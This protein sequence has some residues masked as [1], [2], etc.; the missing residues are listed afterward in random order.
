MPI[1][2]SFDVGIKNMAVC[3]FDC[4][5]EVPSILEWT[6]L[7]MCSSDADSEEKPKCNYITP[8]KKKSESGKECNKVAK[9]K[10]PCHSQSCYF[11]PVHAKK[12]MNIMPTD[13][14]KKTALSKMDITSLHE[15]CDKYGIAKFPTKSASSENLQRHFETYALL[16]ISSAKKKK[17]NEMDL[18]SIGRKMS[19]LLDNM[20]ILKTVDIVI[21]ENQISPIANRMKTIQGMLTQYFII[22]NPECNIEY[23]SS[24]NK[25][26]SFVNKKDDTYKQHKLDAVTIVSGFKEDKISN[27]S[28]W[29]EKMQSAKKKDD[30]ADCFLQ[31]IWYM[32][33]RINNAK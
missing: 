33:S 25:L 2:A 30:L 17:A 19:E 9:Y 13:V 23:V 27:M 31:G 32:N 10:S 3:V 6:I 8:S 15:L 12:T 16:P 22:K 1:L 14:I 11:C 21:I 24:A 7:N 18:V 4:N 28:D 26:K 5:L 29:T 20:P